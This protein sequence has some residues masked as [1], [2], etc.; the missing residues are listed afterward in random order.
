[1]RT[2]SSP[3]RLAIAAS[4][5]TAA[6]AIAW[7]F[8]PGPSSADPGPPSRAAVETTPAGSLDAG[9]ARQVVDALASDIDDLGGKVSASVVSV[10]DGNELASHDATVAMNPASNAKL[11]TAAGALHFLGTEHRF[12]TGLF[13]KVDDGR[14]KELTLRGRGDPSL[15]TADLR[16]L[17]RQLEVAGATEVE[18]IVVDQSFFEGSFVPPAFEQQPNEWAAFRAPTAAVS[19]ERNTVTVWVRPATE[20]KASA[21]VFVDP[22]GFVEIE[23]S[24]RTGAR[25]SAEKIIFDLEPRGDH[26]AA[27]V[28]GSVPLSSKPVPV[29]RRVDDPRTLAGYALRA[30]LREQGVK[31]GD[32]VEA[33]AT[34]EKNALAVRS[35]PALGELL[36][37]LGKDSDNFTAEMLLLAIGSEKEKKPAADAGVRALTDFLKE[38]GALDAGT[39]VKNGSG[40]FDAN[41]ISASS[42]TKVLTWAAKEPAI[43]PEY[44]SHLAIGGVDGTLRSRLKKWGERRAIRAKTG[45]LADVVALSGFVLDERGQPVVAFSFLTSGVKGKTGKA[46]EAIDKAAS[47]LATAVWK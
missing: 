41:R 42:M 25:D 4:V 19:L 34:T 1:M 35:S 11:V 37:R 15:T 14:V 29:T 26:L 46:R 8:E 12:G 32:S 23:G 24:I 3:R 28:R 6:L 45:T 22:P 36:P 27:K 17:A 43:G 30:V 7:I 40:L 47:A 13:G 9:R 18:R 5:W 33:R 16:D 39:V 31:V 10:A 20:E 2:L 44:V 38:R 21:T